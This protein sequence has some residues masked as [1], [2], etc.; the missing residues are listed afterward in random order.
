[1]GSST[2]HNFF[3]WKPDSHALIAIEWLLC[4]FCVHALVRVCQ[5]LFYDKAGLVSTWRTERLHHLH[6]G[7]WWSCNSGD[8]R[9]K[10]LCEEASIAPPSCPKYVLMS[11][12]I[13]HNNVGRR[14]SRRSVCQCAPLWFPPVGKFLYDNG[15]LC[16]S[17]CT[18]CGRHAA[19]TLFAER[20]FRC[21][22]YQTRKDSEIKVPI[23][24]RRRKPI[25]LR[26]YN[27]DR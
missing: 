23:C 9:R 13:S 15:G 1:M 21:S 22:E 2:F 11:S 4:N 17:G 8:C 3:S 6:Q 25:I 24:E 18:G 16:F 7:H 26:D 12:E 5:F 14:D 27:A 10:Q 19:R 20:S